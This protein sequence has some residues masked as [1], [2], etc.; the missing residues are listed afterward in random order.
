[1]KDRIIVCKKTQLLKYK[2]SLIIREML[3]MTI[4]YHSYLSDRQR[5]EL[6]DYTIE[7]ILIKLSL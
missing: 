4:R 6:L 3:I 5:T 2:T 1:M 7:G